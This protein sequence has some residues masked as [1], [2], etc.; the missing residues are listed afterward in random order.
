MFNAIAFRAAEVAA[1]NGL[2]GVLSSIKTGLA[3]FTSANLVKVLL[4]GLAISAP[5]F[6]AWFGYRFVKRKAAAGITKG[7]LG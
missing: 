6:L 7:K 3:D 4:A 1:D 5:L 2:D